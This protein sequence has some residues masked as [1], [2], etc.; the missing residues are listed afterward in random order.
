MSGTDVSSFSIPSPADG[1]SVL[2]RTAVQVMPIF[3]VPDTSES[4]VLV[5]W[6]PPFFSVFRSSHSRQIEKSARSGLATNI[7]SSGR[8]SPSPT[9]RGFT[10]S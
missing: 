8:P 5:A 6:H 2:S 3:P 1:P 10:G 9:P 4:V 7:Q